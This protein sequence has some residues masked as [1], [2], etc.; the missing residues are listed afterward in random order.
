M[1]SCVDSLRLWLYYLE[2]TGKYSHLMCWLKWPTFDIQMCLICERI[3]MSNLPTFDI[4]IFPLKL[5]QS[6]ATRWKTLDSW[7]DITPWKQPASLLTWRPTKFRCLNYD[8][9]M[10]SK[11]SI[12]ANGQMVLLKVGNEQE[13]L[14]C[15]INFFV[16]G[17]TVALIWTLLLGT[18]EVMVQAQMLSVFRLGNRFRRYNEHLVMTRTWLLLLF[19]CT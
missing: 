11:R 5:F 4:E 3:C 17:E 8:D 14:Q 13:R 12:F 19:V 16:R 1:S 18:D 10:I 6:L 15:C 7:M 2:Y 9:R